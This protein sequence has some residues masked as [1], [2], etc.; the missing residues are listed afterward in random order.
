MTFSR[1]SLRSKAFLLGTAALVIA[2]TAG[3]VALTTASPSPRVHTSARVGRASVTP[4]LL[5]PDTSAPRSSA[6]SSIT[7]PSTSSS[8]TTATTTPPGPPYRVEDHTIVLLDSS[9]TTPA[10]GPVAAKPGRVLRTIIRR[11]AGLSGPLPL[12]VFAH[13]YDSEPE[14]YEP[15]LDEWAA[16]GYMVAA[17]ECPGSA[18]DLP[19]NPVPDY[20]AQARD[21]SFVITS[22]LSGSTGQV[23]PHEIA[24]AGHSDGGTAVTIMALNAPYADPRVKAYLNLAGQIP[25]DVPGPWATTTTPGDLLVAVGDDDQ[26]GNLALSTAM[27]GAAKMP[28]VLLTVPG[29]DHLGTFVASSPTAEAV[30]AATTR[31]LGAVFGA[32]PQGATAAQLRGVL[33]GSGAPQPFSVSA[34]D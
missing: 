16:A 7:T 34:G 23:D 13:G 18:H 10:R 31:F 3:T 12:V 15:L 20:A 24:V 22:L 8:T 26:Y 32:G 4:R 25:P 29:G 28:K 30:R 5:P 2:V 11:P 21:I 33:E 1:A 14:V 27:F 19:G 9:R 6:S 17:P